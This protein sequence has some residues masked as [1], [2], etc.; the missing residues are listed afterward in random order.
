MATDRRT[1]AV[2]A[3]MVLAVAAIAAA[4]FVKRREVETRY[5]LWRLERDGDV[6]RPLEKL[7]A[8][9]AAVDP[10]LVEALRVVPADVSVA[11][12]AT[13]TARYSGQSLAGEAQLTRAVV[14]NV[15][16]R[17]LVLVGHLDVDVLGYWK[18]SGAGVDA[19]AERVPPSLRGYDWGA[20]TI[21][22][23]ARALAPGESIALDHLVRFGNDVALY[24][25]RAT[26][27]PLDGLLLGRDG[28]DTPARSLA[29]KKLSL[30]RTR[31]DD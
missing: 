27:V 13:T 25:T 28:R 23:Q 24:D 10:R 2:A 6:A 17:R 26:L 12:T 19:P 9:G 7:L 11:F 30:S 29:T 22:R 5:W 20:A 31:K 4:A 18:W 3:T 15:S 21:C 14:T 16:S 8:L 1:R